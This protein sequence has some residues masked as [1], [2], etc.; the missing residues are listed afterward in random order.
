MVLNKLTKLG[1][2]D[3]Y[4][5]EGLIKASEMLVAPRIS[6][7]FLKFWNIW[8]ILEHLEKFLEFGKFRKFLENSGSFENVKFFGNFWKILKILKF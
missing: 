5:I 3:R 2:Y 4:T 8:K 6:E 1:R 7:F